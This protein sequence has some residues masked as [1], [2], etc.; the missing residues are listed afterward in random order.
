M[1]KDKTDQGIQI[2]LR[3]RPSKK[4]SGFL[5]YDNSDDRGL[6]FHVPK[7]EDL[8][9][10]NTRTDYKFKFNGILKEQCGQ[11]EVFDK[12]GSQAVQNALD[13]FNSTIFAYGQTGSGKTFTI[14]GGS[15]RYVDRGI[16]PRAISMLFSEFAKN[17]ETQYSC[18]ISYLEIYNDK[19]YDLLDSDHES[20]ARLEDLKKVMML[21]DEDGNY[22]L[23]NLSMH[24]VSS[25]EDALNCL[26]LG[27]TNRAISETDMNQAS[28]R[29]HCIFTV[30]I[31][32]RKQG[33]D[34]VTRSK[35]HL[36][37]LAGSERVHKTSTTGQTL[38]EAKHINS[39]LFYL[40]MVIVA[41]HEK[42]NNA[43]SHI[44]YRNSMMTSVLRDSLGGNCKTV[45]VATISPESSHTDE[46]IS[47]CNFAQRVA[48]IK[49]VAQKNEDLDP[50]LM[51]TRLKAELATLREEIKYLK[52]EAGE[53]YDLTDDQRAELEKLC[54]VYVDERNPMAT[55]NIGTMTLVKIKDVH[56][57]FKNLV[58][59]AR[60]NGGGSSS[61]V[62][63]DKQV[64]LLKNSLQQRDNEIAIL[65]NMVKQ[66][67]K[68]P[69]TPATGEAKMIRGD[70]SRPAEVKEVSKVIP[71]TNNR[72]RVMQ[73]L[74]EKT[75]GGVGLC[76]SQSTLDDPAQS[77]TWFKERYPG[78]AAIEENKAL[79]KSK[80]AEA[81]E[82]GEK[83]NKAR[84]NI[85]YLKT[86]IEQL[87][88]E[89]AM[90]RV[91]EGEESKHEGKEDDG[92][93]DPEEARHR[94]GI[95]MSK[96]IY[97][98]NFNKLKELKHAIEHIQRLLEKSRTKLQSDFD[99][100]YKHNIDFLNRY[101]SLRNTESAGQENSKP[102]VYE[103]QAQAKSPL[104]RFP[105]QAQVPKEPL[106]A[107]LT[108]NK[109]ADEDIMAFYKAKEELLKR[110]AQAK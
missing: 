36:V 99:Q 67:K 75:V 105:P 92:E 87:R 52:G 50:A 9:V 86:T 82:T 27:D 39:S 47:T 70:S 66:G 43:R 81:K 42:G 11:E 88:R 57:I 16:I 25:E 78:N 55:L 95:E 60:E 74:S 56:A 48:L 15:E 69:G 53:G 102:V 84:S 10:N 45:M 28:S 23:K 65:V 107:K 71:A 20:T 6:A 63:A 90:E 72:E 64:A 8:Y 37:D 44:P 7:S 38:R 76:K 4:P 30:S 101:G 2:F 18:F 21:E 104:P 34:T 29:S 94:K 49:N 83:V 33:S 109:E 17:T 89:R 24:P 73:Q 97:K 41:L 13:G 85:N 91:V 46:S 98:E 54:R 32:G 96:F 31:E 12:V 110:N 14:T 68:M 103:A 79:L 80:Y 106:G 26:F 61:D 22:H 77:F 5:N 40:E 51:I 108:G 59:E 100:W 35:L 19:G 93:V 58:L 1:P 3:V 62:D